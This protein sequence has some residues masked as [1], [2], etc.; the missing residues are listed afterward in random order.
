LEETV[1]VNSTI[2]F[3][4][5]SKR[6]PWALEE[7]GEV[8]ALRTNSCQCGDAR[9]AERGLTLLQKKGFSRE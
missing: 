9:L 5:E 4:T 2:I 3:R 1:G 7:N 6:R 8:L